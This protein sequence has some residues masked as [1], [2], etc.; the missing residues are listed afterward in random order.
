[1]ST[2]PSVISSVCTCSAGTHFTSADP[3]WRR[4]PHADA[5]GSKVTAT[6]GNS[7]AQ[8]EARYGPPA[9]F[10]AR[11]SGGAAVDTPGLAPAPRRVPSARDVEARAEAWR[12]WRAQ[13]AIH[14][15]ALRP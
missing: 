12:P 5:A 13:A 1:M 9:A 6:Q 2:S 3:A 4:P 10:L 15:W 7:R 14:L 8:G 11:A